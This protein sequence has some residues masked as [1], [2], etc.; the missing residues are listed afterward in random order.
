MNNAKA[1]KITELL[2]KVFTA[3]DDYSLVAKYLELTEKSGMITIFPNGKKQS[4][5]KDDR[6]FITR[7]CDWVLNYY[8]L[9]GVCQKI[10]PKFDNEIDGFEYAIID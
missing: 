10:T 8:Q 9:I 7:C 5:S 1:K 3:T 6:S 4:F 2:N